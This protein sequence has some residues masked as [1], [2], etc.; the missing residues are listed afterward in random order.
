MH[1]HICMFP[2]CDEFELFFCSVEGITSQDMCARLCDLWLDTLPTFKGS[3]RES[4]IHNT[5][6][7]CQPIRGLCW[8]RM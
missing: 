3:D 4:A 7:G 2:N 8:Y 6:L 1:N 5:A